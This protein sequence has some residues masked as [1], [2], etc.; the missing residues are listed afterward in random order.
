MR[1]AV[2]GDRAAPGHLVSIERGG[3]RLVLD[4]SGSPASR[5]VL[6]G[7][8]ADRATVPVLER[9]VRPGM[10]VVD[11]G[12]RV[13][14]SALVASR[15][16]GPRG[17]VV[18][19]EPDAANC[20]L[21]LL[22]ASVNECTNL[23]VWPVALHDHQGWAQLAPGGLTAGGPAELGAGVGAVVPTFPLDQL[24]QG[25]IDVLRLD[26]SGAERLVLAGARRLLSGR[27]P[28]I[29]SAVCPGALQRVSGC[30][31]LQLLGDLA[32]VGYRL[33]RV[34]AD[35]G[36]VHPIRDLPAFAGSLEDPSDQAHVLL[37]PY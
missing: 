7:R 9:H 13:G 5:A 1:P 21:L 12:A 34:D 37:L 36:Q 33:G 24:L 15:L 6:E 8:H 29:L 35:S 3:V 10:T 23:A 31:V 19:V 11:V 20:R 2:R 22:S 26:A 25:P 32:G 28:V 16:V 4:P 17:H 30:T 27:R 18:A 14:A